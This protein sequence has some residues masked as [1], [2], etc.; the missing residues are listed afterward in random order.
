MTEVVVATGAMRGAKLQSDRHHQQT[1]I[2]M[3]FL[4][5]IQ[6]CRSTKGKTTTHYNGQFTFFLPNDNV[7]ASVKQ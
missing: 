7:A 1:N 5:P 4:S 2:R 6:Q 3:P